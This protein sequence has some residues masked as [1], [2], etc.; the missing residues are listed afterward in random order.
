[1]SSWVTGFST[2]SGDEDPTEEFNSEDKKL[3][4]RS[5]CFQKMPRLVCED[6]LRTFLE[7]VLPDINTTTETNHEVLNILSD[8]VQLR[9]N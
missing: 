8:L 1:M 3:E 4:V 6:C 2:A 9:L 5:C 7:H